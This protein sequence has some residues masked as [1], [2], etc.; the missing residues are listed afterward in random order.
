MTNPYLYLD[1]EADG[2]LEASTQVW[3]IVAFDGEKYLI[4]HIDT[5]E[6]LC[7]PKTYIVYKDIQEYLSLL[8][9]YTLVIHN[10]IS[11][12]LPL[13][14]KL[15]GYKYTVSRDVVVDTLLLSSLLYPDREGGHSLESWGERL[16]FK[17]GEHTDWSCFSNTML[18]YCIRDVDVL[19]R[20]H[21]ALQEEMQDWDW[22][23]AIDIEYRIA[24]IMTRQESYGV[25]FDSGKAESLL[26]R[27]EEELSEIESKA[28]LDIPL[29]AKA[30]G[31]EVM[32]PFKKNGEY[33]QAVI[34]WIGEQ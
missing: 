3:C 9:S 22:S 7:Y 34:D 2:L 29:T 11:Y 15:Y 30:V 8:S 23:Q 1:I 17:K 19:R 24:D 10:G 16:K 31:K 14:D 33:S 6:E 4:W 26:S 18:Q 28:L 13:L 12:D 27:I 32:K 25:L 21:L 20:V 5:E